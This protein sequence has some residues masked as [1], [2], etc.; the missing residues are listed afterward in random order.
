ML[1]PVHVGELWACC[2]ISDEDRDRDVE[3]PD[4]AVDLTELRPDLVIDVGII[5]CP[6]HPRLMRWHL[7]LRRGLPHLKGTLKL[8]ELY[9]SACGAPICKLF[10]LWTYLK[11][12][13]DTAVYPTWSPC[14]S[15][16]VSLTTRPLGTLL[17]S[18]RRS[19]KRSWVLLTWLL[20]TRHGEHAPFP[21]ETLSLL[22]SF[23][24]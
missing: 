23:F 18:P 9:F 13:A 7:K 4:V 16:A 1:D 17:C 14:W 8:I 5:P 19:P 3:S 15:L 20:Q 2:H 22:C 6:E 10:D 24:F 12:S 21:L 11:S